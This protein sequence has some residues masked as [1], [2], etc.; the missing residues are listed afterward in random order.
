MEKVERVRVRGGD[1][2][3]RLWGGPIPWGNVPRSCLWRQ[4]GGRSVKAI[5]SVLLAELNRSWRLKCISEISSL[6]SWIQAWLASCGMGD[7]CKCDSW[8][9]TSLLGLKLLK[10]RTVSRSW[11][12]TMSVNCVHGFLRTVKWERRICSLIIQLTNVIADKRRKGLRFCN[13]AWLFLPYQG[14]WVWLRQQRV[15]TVPAFVCH[16]FF[17]LSH[18]DSKLNVMQ[19]ESFLGSRNNRNLSAKRWW[20]GWESISPFKLLN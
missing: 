13:T 4:L 17:L 19:K 12:T 15:E 9:P 6:P 2:W 10:D 7:L 1:L 3:L 18:I 16:L 11:L 8:I 20:A 5:Q 14:P